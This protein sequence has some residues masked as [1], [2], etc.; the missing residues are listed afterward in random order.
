MDRMISWYLDYWNWTIW[1][2][3][4]TRTDFEL[5]SGHMRTWNLGCLL[6]FQS[7]TVR[8]VILDIDIGLGLSLGSDFEFAWPRGLTRIRIGPQLDLELC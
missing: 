5:D 7:W 4:E 3:F 6:S 8:I 1:A 2:E